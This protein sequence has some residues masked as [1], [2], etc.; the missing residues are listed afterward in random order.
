M[1]IRKGFTPLE[2]PKMCVRKRFLTGFSLIEISIT[3]VVFILIFSG[4]LGIF[5]Q[6]FS[7]LKESKERTI[8][9]N[10]AREKLEGLPWPPIP[11]VRAG[12]GNFS[13]FEREVAVTR[14]YLGYNN[15][16]HIKVTVWWDAGT[17]SQ[18]FDALKADY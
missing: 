12:V 1:A 17:Q 14:P 13:G 7:Y 10:L 5:A 2:I 3:L 18:A 8:A 11:K 4:M 16:A 15:L 9:Y 6:G